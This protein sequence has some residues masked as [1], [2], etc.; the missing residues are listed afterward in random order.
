MEILECGRA[1]TLF[2]PQS[3]QQNPERSEQ[4]LLIQVRNLLELVLMDP[5]ARELEPSQ[6]L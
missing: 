2:F 1:I 6:A 4:H 5:H 3:S